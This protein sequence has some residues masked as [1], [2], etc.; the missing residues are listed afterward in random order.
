MFE[1]IYFFQPI[2]FSI[3][4][5]V[6]GCTSLYLEGQSSQSPIGVD[7]SLS[8]PEKANEWH[9]AL[10]LLFGTASCKLKPDIMILDLIKKKLV[11]LPPPPTPPLMYLIVSNKGFS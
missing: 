5:K 3:Y 2:I 4:F 6:C 9:I 7:Q 8:T 11:N 10:G 1:R